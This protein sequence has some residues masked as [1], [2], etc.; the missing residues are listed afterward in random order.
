M[1]LGVVVVAAMAV[2]GVVVG[3]PTAVAFSFGGGV[4]GGRSV[5]GVVAAGIQKC[6]CW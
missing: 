6:W 2:F 3:V 5:G 1:S 4:G